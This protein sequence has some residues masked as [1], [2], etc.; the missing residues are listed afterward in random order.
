M[1]IAFTTKENYKNIVNSNLYDYI[2]ITEDNTEFNENFL[3][4]LEQVINKY[5]PDIIYSDYSIIHDSYEERIYG[6]TI[7]FNEMK[8][9][10]N[11]IKNAAIKL[12]VVRKFGI[13]IDAIVRPEN[14]LLIWHIPKT[15][16]KMKGK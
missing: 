10:P 6:K 12:S 2:I 13:E 1:S 8:S 5:S 3:G 14:N 15:L 9:K 11:F 7:I 4:E 16:F